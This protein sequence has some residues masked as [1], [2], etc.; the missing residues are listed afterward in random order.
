MTDSVFT[1]VQSDHSYRSI[2]TMRSVQWVERGVGG[3]LRIIDQRRLPQTLQYCEL[4]DAD[5]VVD[6]IRSLAIRGANSIGAAGAFGFAF[7]VRD[8]LSANQASDMVAQARPTAV[9]LRHGV[10]RA[11]RRYVEHA[12]WRDAVRAGQDII[13]ADVEECRLIGEIGARELANATTILTH[14]N[15]GILA[16]AGIGTALGV[17]YTKH[18]QGQPVRVYAT[19]TRPLRQ[20]L[21]LTT[22]ELERQGVSVTALVDGAA[23]AALHRG[24]IDAVVVGAD[25]IALN[26]D[27]ANK[28]GTYGLAVA[29]HSN[30]VPFYVAAP[31]SAIDATAQNEHDIPIESRAGAEVLDVPGVNQQLKTWNPAFDVTP[32]G[33]I[34]GIITPHGVLRPPFERSIADVISLAGDADAQESQVSRDPVKA[35]SRFVPRKGE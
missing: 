30:H 29:A 18:A 24:L 10:Q 8:G 26:G 5:A 11:F 23:P 33:L 7:A 15:T 6:A 13:R 35:G 12:D 3:V 22:W 19:E 4:E 9:T 14:C 16:T 32:S 34:S 1:A 17:V 2:T 31:L 21:R 25:R 20:G 27:T 28:I